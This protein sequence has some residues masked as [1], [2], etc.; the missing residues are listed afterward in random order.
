M[1][2]NHLFASAA[3]LLAVPMFFANAGDG[4]GA[5]DG[6]G[7]E[8]PTPELIRDA[9]TR[10]DP[11]NKAHWT[12]A[13]KPSIEAIE[14]IIGKSISR[15]EVNV[16]A[17]D[18]HRP[19]A[20]ETAGGDRLSPEEEARVSAAQALAKSDAET[21]DDAPGATVDP[22]R[23]DMG[24]RQRLSDTRTRAAELRSDA[25]RTD[26]GGPASDTA[27]G[28]TAQELSDTRRRERLMKDLGP[29]DDRIEALMQSDTVDARLRRV[30]SRE[31]RIRHADNRRLRNNAEYIA[32]AAIAAARGAHAAPDFV[33]GG[34]VIVH[35]RYYYEGRFYEAGQKI[36]GFVG[37]LGLKMELST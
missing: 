21:G 37:R 6:S 8:R 28:A 30:M 7:G 35:D 32:N 27:A 14:A 33:A 20:A 36:V 1:I 18:A 17:P 25:A 10:L 12:A 16:A 26:T 5:G 19:E 34:T 3:I 22:R 2:R 29:D 9:I 31:Q 15:A 23:M 4:G 11:E 24:E 13:G